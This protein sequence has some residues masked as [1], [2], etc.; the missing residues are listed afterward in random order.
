MTEEQRQWLHETHRLWVDAEN[1]YCDESRKYTA[2]GDGSAVPQDPEKVFDR[3]G[4]AAARLTAMRDK[5]QVAQD[6]YLQAIR[7]AP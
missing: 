5:A 1:A 7:D 6:V 4:T 2:V 3:E